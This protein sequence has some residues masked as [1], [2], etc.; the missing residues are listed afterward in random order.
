MDTRFCDQCECY[1]SPR[2]RHECDTCGQ[3]FCPRCAASHAL[4]HCAPFVVIDDDGY[5]LTT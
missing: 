2:R 5:A 3:M 1:V 4:H